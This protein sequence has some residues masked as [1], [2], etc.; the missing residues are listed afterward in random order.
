MDYV[1]GTSGGP[2]SSEELLVIRAKL[3]RIFTDDQAPD[4]YKQI[5]DTG[6][7]APNPK[8]DLAFFAAKLLRLSFHDCLRYEDGSGGCDGC[9]NW[10][11]VGVRFP[12]AKTIQFKFKYPDVKATNNNGMEHAVAVMEELYT[13]PNFP[14]STPQ[15]SSSL[16]ST[17]K[18]RADLWSFA[19]KVAVEFS[20]EQ[21]NF[22]CEMKP[23]AWAGSYVGIS[24]DCHRSLEKP[25]CKVHL[26]REIKFFYGRKD[27]IT[28]N[29]VPYKADK[30]EVHPNQ[31]GNGDSTIDFFKSQYNFTGRETVAIMGG[32]TLGRMYASHSLLK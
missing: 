31:E 5:P 19:A 13:N 20:I 23:T 8:T 22:Q 6:L 14:E 7:P 2:W 21:N 17:G 28:S 10:E 9:L 29:E 30:E 12:T 16:K 27:C 25:D 11:G 24:Q 1:P 32:H 26:P 18:S 3:W 4:I 15:L